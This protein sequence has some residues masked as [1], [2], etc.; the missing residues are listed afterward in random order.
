MIDG[1][2]FIIPIIIAV[3]PATITVVPPANATAKAD[4]PAAI[5]IK[6]PPINTVPTP[7]NAIAPATANKPGAILL[8]NIPATP[9]IVNAVAIA[10]SAATN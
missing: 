5:N 8:N 9:S 4:I 7:N 1:I 6:P 2:K 3:K 10:I